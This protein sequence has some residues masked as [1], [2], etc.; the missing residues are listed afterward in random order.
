MG[1]LP[2][3]GV[4]GNDVPDCFDNFCSKSLQTNQ[5]FNQGK[6]SKRTNKAPVQM[7]FHDVSGTGAQQCS[8]GS[9]LRWCVGS[10]PR[11]GV[12][13]A[14][15][16]RKGKKGNRLGSCTHKT[17]GFWP[18]DMIRLTTQVTQS[19]GGYYTDVSTAQPRHSATF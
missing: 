10:V 17:T 19:D 5:R 11:G 3:Q 15:E 2:V 14:L 16:T 4:Q 7:T 9:P 13:I 6:D 18:E 8:P 1:Y 12:V